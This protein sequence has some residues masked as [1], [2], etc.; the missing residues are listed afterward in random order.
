MALRHLTVL[1]VPYHPDESDARPS[2]TLPWFPAVGAAIGVP[3]AVVLLLPLPALPRAALAL[4]AWIVVTGAL[5]EDG[6]MDCA[7]AAF[8]PVVR[9]RRLEILED[10]RAGAFAVT[11][12]G[13]MLLT[14][15]AALTAVAALAPV[16][17]SLIGRWAMTISLACW[18][19]AR[20]EGLGARFAD[21]AGASKPTVVAVTLLAAGAA[22]GDRSGA[23]QACAAVVLGLGAG[24]LLAGWLSRRFGGLTGDAHGAVG[25]LAETAA[26]IAYLPVCGGAHGC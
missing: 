8:A 13:L 23:L 25:V 3:A 16:V 9:E 24:L 10:P 1:P 11:A 15:F 22:A 18:R 5:H 4:A 12:E 19:P 2:R 14:R 26:L 20:R 7:D 17:A 21:G 6:L